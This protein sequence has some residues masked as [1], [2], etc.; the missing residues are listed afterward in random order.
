MVKKVYGEDENP[1]EVMEYLKKLYTKPKGESL[2]VPVKEAI[3]GT[4]YWRATW[5]C[6]A[7]IIFGQFTGVNAIMWY[8]N[9]IITHMHEAGGGISPRLGTVMIGLAGFFGAFFAMFTAK[10]F[11]RRT[12]VFCGHCVMGVELIL[13]GIFAFYLYN[14]AALAFIM[15]FLIT[16]QL[17]DGSLT[18]LYVAEVVTDAALGFCFL[19]LKGTALII[20]LTT[21]YIMDSPL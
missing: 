12:L 8:S 19:T 1:E 13:V 5:F 18:Y 2:Q 17:T 3:V 6:V 14:N 9:S 7:F 10:R 11:G 21:E 16:Y 4:K 20:S 15:I